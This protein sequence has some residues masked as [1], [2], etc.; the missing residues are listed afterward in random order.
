M[1]EEETSLDVVLNE[2]MNEEIFREP[3]NELLDVMYRLC[4][5]SSQ[6]DLRRALFFSE[7]LGC[8]VSEQTH[9]HAERIRCLAQPYELLRPI[10]FELSKRPGPS[11]TMSTF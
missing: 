10:F 1:S 7:S 5:A 8:G 2:A 4:R 11:S 9:P 6:F 3:L